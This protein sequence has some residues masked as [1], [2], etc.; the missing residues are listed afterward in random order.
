MDEKISR[1]RF[2]KGLGLLL[3]GTALGCG[4]QLTSG[5]IETS[6]PLTPQEKLANWLVAHPEYT[7]HP[8]DLPCHGQMDVIYDPAKV[9]FN[10]ESYRA[11]V[12]WISRA[13]TSA[14][15]GK[16]Q[17]I[18]REALALYATSV[19]QTLG[20]KATVLINTTQ[21][22]FQINNI[23][24]PEQTVQVR[25]GMGA[26]TEIFATITTG[27]D[28]NWSLIVGTTHHFQDRDTFHENPTREEANTVSN[29][30]EQIGNG[31]F[32]VA[33]YYT[34]VG[35]SPTEAGYAAYAKWVEETAPN[36][37]L[38]TGEAV[39]NPIVD[40]DTFAGFPAAA[41]WPITLLE[42][43][44]PALSSGTLFEQRFGRV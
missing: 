29:V 1:R 44:N 25:N 40:F 41:P 31:L 3:A 22:A 13:V 2:L 15:E 4:P 12:E 17:R 23:S 28:S 42:Q 21:S 18:D 14:T 7:T 26:L 20:P 43:P 37:D 39:P 35:A 8:V 32:A 33:W 11:Y 5:P 34:T 38:P 10:E 30:S 24:S 9:M 36:L 27:Q 19:N 16:F 6:Q